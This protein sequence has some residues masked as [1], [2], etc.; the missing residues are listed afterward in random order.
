MYRQMSLYVLNMESFVIK[1]EILVSYFCYGDM[2]LKK[3]NI[4]HVRYKFDKNV[5][6]NRV[7]I[8]LR[9]SDCYG[10]VSESWCSSG[11]ASVSK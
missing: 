3:R 5:K 9:L 1:R 11:E 2:L 6:S 4:Y 10:F 8:A 7:P